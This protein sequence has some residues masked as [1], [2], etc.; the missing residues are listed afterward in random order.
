MLIINPATAI[1]KP[2]HTIDPIPVIITVP[3]NKN[4]KIIIIQPSILKTTKQRSP[5]QNKTI[6]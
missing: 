1:P 2:L 3:T 5:T 4:N 6:P